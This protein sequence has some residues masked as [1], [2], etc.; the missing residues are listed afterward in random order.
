M[1]NH[2]QLRQLQ[3]LLENAQIVLIMYGPNPTLDELA[4]A[5]ALQ[6]GLKRSGKDASLYSP[7]KP[8]LD[9]AE[10]AKITKTEVG[11]Q[12]LV[13]SFDYSEEAVDKVSYHI[14]EETNRFYLTIKPSR[15]HAPLDA[16]TIDYSYT[17]AEADI[18][19]MV[20][21]DR[22]EDLEQLYIGYEDLYSN[23]PIVTL[24]DLP[25]NY[26]TIKLGADSASISEAAATVLKEL[27]LSINPDIATNLLS[28]IEEAT[29]NMQT[30][31]TTA[32]TFE[33]AAHLLRSGAVRQP[34]M[35]RH[36]Q[37]EAQMFEQMQEPR[38]EPKAQ[39][40]ME[41]KP[42]SSQP[43][44]PKQSQQPRQQKQQKQQSKQSKQQN[45]QGKKKQNSNPPQGGISRK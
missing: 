35:P 13:V 27:Q 30:L 8:Q 21:V 4:A 15:G 7:E 37:D 41:E 5:A 34:H 16:D 24:N 31:D 6:D 40:V 26:G 1:I 45:Q 19:F 10:A 42:R 9:A 29:D 2:E 20:G 23:T 18:I 43:Q 28:G 36:R 33:I 17:G 14:G 12:N 39:E 25:T 11:N 44:Q 32:D 38:L 22:L 3:S